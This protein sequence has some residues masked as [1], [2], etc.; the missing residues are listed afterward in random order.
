MIMVKGNQAQRKSDLIKHGEGAAH[1]KARLR[2]G[3]ILI[4][5]GWEIYPNSV[6]KVNAEVESEP[7]ACWLFHDTNY[8][9]EFDIYC[10]KEH[11]NGLV[12]ELIIEIDGSSHNSKIQQG[13]DK[14]AEQYARFFLPDARFVRIPIEALLGDMRDL[15]ICYWLEIA[16]KP[17]R[18]KYLKK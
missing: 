15:D 11:D 16:D 13:K 17:T 7:P 6:L 8:Y 4:N 18:Q 12:S 5:N 2:L 14:T 3:N 10:R 9:H 1:E